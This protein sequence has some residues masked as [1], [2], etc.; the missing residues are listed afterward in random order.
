MSADD[1]QF[2]PHCDVSNDLHNGPDSCA[3]AEHKANMLEALL[4]IFGGGR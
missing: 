1:D 3:Y 2:C 4:G